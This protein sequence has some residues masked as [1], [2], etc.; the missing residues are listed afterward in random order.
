[1]GFAHRREHLNKGDIVVATCTHQCNV[2]LTTDAHFR[3]YR[4]RERF[5]GY[6]GWCRTFPAR[7]LLLA[8]VESHGGS[9]DANLPFI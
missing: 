5:D 9:R 1:M 7:N 4:T 2:M 3:R 6:G 8:S